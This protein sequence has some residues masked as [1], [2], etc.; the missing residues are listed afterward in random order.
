MSEVK[1][2][3]ATYQHG[4]DAYLCHR[5]GFYWDRGDEVPEC[6]T[7][8]QIGQEALG[9]LKAEVATHDH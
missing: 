8:Q 6:K 9:R 4:N 7:E 5:C 1:Q 2:C 3:Q